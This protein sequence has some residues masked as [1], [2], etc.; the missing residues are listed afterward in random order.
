MA[1]I[2]ELRPE[3][4]RRSCP[5]DRFEF[6]D[7]AQLAEEGQIIGQDRAVEA[8][9]FGINIENDGFN[10]Y[11]LGRQGSGK[12]TTIRRFVQ[13]KARSRPVPDDWC[14]RYNFDEPEKPRALRLPAGWG[15]ELRGDMERLVTEIPR[16]ISRALEREDLRSEREAAMEGLQKQQQERF[17][18]LEGKAA[19]KGFALERN[20][21]GI[22]VVPLRDGQPISRDQFDELPDEEKERIQREGEELNRELHDTVHGVRDLEKS[23]REQMRDLER[24]TVLFAVQY[25]LETLRG[26]YESYPQVVEYLD[27]VREDILDNARAIIAKSTAEGQQGEQNPLAMMQMQVQQRSNILER[28]RV[29]LIVDNSGAE[30]APVIMEEIPSF[31]HLIGRVERQ[32]RLGML[33]TSF[34]MIKAGALHRANGGYLILEAEHL[35]RQPL[36]YDGLKHA[37]REG[38]IKITDPGEMV[39]PISTAGLEP[40]PIPLS[41]KVIVTGSPPIYYL[42]HNLDGEFQELFKVKADFDSVMDRTLENERRYAAFMAGRCREEGWLPFDRSGI[43]RMVEYGSELAGDQTRLSTQFADIC[44]LGREANYWA[45]REG[46]RHIG[47]SHLQRAVDAR[48]RRANRVEDRLQEMIR[49]EEI[50]IDTE[51]EVVG[52]VNGLAVV[53]L[54]DY[55]FGHPSRITARTYARR[56]GVINIEREAKMSGPIHDKGVLILSGFLNGRYGRSR[57]VALQASLGFEQSYQGVDGDS[58]SSAELY[59][60]LSSLSGRPLRQC[61]AVTGSVNQRGEIQPIGGATQKIEGFFEVCKARGL[62][63]SQGVLIPRANV[64]NLMLRQ[65]VVE[66]VREGRFH[67]YPVETIDEGIEILTGAPAGEAQ[68]GG[69]YPEGSVNRAVEERLV[70]LAEQWKEYG[71]GREP[72]D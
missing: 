19:E 34:D 36:A 6:Q 50:F 11:A 18:E 45:G 35:L 44:D 21:T 20:P 47:R 32:A 52:Q 61:L 40:E 63:G 37:L 57:P 33:V 31:P 17:A 27:E 65:E 54:G 71:G 1:R 4:L 8:I 62:S 53:S 12:T 5:E 49:R 15:R 13:E 42:L 9:E 30:G 59:A 22:F 28:Y 48:R 69:A 2:A 51:G 24:K 10:I 46:S 25:H 64:T 60:L 72:G 3:E 41:V 66:A 55:A 70:E 29:N 58:A 14:Y 43:A 67:I 7:T 16:E 39:S 26:K 68:A 38:K 56:G 23:A